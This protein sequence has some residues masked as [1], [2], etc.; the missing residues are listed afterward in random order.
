MAVQ[1]LLPLALAVP[2]YFASRWGTGFIIPHLRLDQPNERSSHV[3]PTPRGGGIA[4]L[5]VLLPVWAALALAGAVPAAILAAVAAA[6]GLAAISFL[7]DLKDLPAGWRLLVQAAAVAAGLAVLPGA[8]GVFQGILPVWLDLALTALL[9]LW[10]V[11]LFNFMD[12]IDGI[13]GCEAGFLGVGIAVAALFG[14]PE[15]DIWLGLTLAAAVLGFLKWNWHPA[16]VFM[17]DVG[18]IPL[19]FLLGFL[20]LAL[21]ARGQWAAAL[22]M[23]L[24]Y[25]G[26]ASWTLARRLLRGEKIWQ[27]HREHCYQRAVQLGRRHDGVVR[28]I[29]ITNALLLMLALG[30]L[31]G[32]AW[33]PLV[34]GGILAAG[35][36]R[37]LR[38]L[39]SGC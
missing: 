1:T 13:T 23:P 16:R 27:A 3:N 4:I 2:V 21:A 11:N 24:Y 37:A 14:G 15:G 39:P 6:A 29:A 38:R 31:S 12:G 33:G 34:M 19:G 30:C 26:D 17:G 20:L 18:S 22:L 8:G 28:Q 35:Q 32:E 36:L 7:D 10:F 9:W 25:L 5:A